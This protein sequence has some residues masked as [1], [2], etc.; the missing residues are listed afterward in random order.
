MMAVKT[1]SGFNFK[2]R[3]KTGHKRAGQVL[4][5]METAKLKADKTSLR[6]LAKT[7]KAVTKTSV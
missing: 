6:L 3:A 7:N 4:T 1:S 5:P 2:R